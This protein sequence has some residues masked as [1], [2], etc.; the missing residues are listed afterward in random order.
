MLQTMEKSLCSYK[1]N[2]LRKL[3]T[4]WLC[5]IVQNT[6]NNILLFPKSYWKLL[7]LREQYF[8]FK[9]IFISFLHCKIILSCSAIHFVRFVRIRSF[10][11]SVFSHILCG[12]WD[13]LFSSLYLVQIQENKDQ[14]KIRIWTLLTECYWPNV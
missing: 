13:S 9:K 11:W 14:K 3:I 1:I 7:R 6:M 4:H 8:L 2:Y 5:Y 10:F 12:Y